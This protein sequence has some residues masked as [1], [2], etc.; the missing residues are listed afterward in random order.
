MEI[1]WYG[2][3]CFRLTERGKTTVITDPYDPTQLGITPS[4]VIKADLVT[5]SHDVP[6]HNYLQG[7]VS[8]GTPYVLRGAGEYEIGGT[9]LTGIPLH[10]I[11]DDE[12][13]LNIGYVVQYEGVNV[14]HLGDL[15]HV[16]STALL[17]SLGDVHV[18]LVPVGGRNTLSA[19]QASE[20]ITLIEPNY[21]IPMHYALPNLTVEL[22]EVERFLKVMGISNA[23]TLD[24][25]KVTGEALPEEMEV[26]LLQASI[27]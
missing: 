23:T 3:S 24:T 20:I 12:V 2:H 18:L 11:Q 13:V 7:V 21:V 26:V 22:D 4:G 5:I 15:G 16:P 19:S 25:L 14:L 8:K 17:Q 9:F 6:H 27:E 1:T 10:H